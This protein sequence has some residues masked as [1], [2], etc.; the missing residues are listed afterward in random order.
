MKILHMLP[1]LT[2]VQ[3]PLVSKSLTRAEHWLQLMS[4]YWQHDH[5]K[6]TVYLRAPS[7]FCIIYGFRQR[8]YGTYSSS[9]YQSF[10]SFFWYLKNPLWSACSPC[11]SPTMLTTGPFTI[12]TVLPFSRMSQVGVRHNTDFPEWPLSLVMHLRFLH[13]S[14]FP[15]AQ[16]IR[17]PLSFMWNCQTLSSKEDATFCIPTNGELLLFSI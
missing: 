8:H 2:H 4:P 3:F 14:G 1:A 11:P 5:P 7:W 15:G 13:I 10:F 17:N 9:Q 12:P 16:L 6:S